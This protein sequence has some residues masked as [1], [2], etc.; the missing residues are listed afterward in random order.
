MFN[1]ITLLGNLGEDA[2]M[3]Y[4]NEGVAVTHFR[5]AVN[6]TWMDDAGEK[7]EKTVW[8][9]V[10]AWRKLAETCGEYLAKG[11]QVLVVGDLEEASAYVDKEGNARASNEVTARRVVF[12][13]GKSDGEGA[14]VAPSPDALPDF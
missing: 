3:S 13:G 12:L 2:Q 14:D 1:H 11:R 10:T 6:R 7:H 9:R 5:M 8:I 4:T